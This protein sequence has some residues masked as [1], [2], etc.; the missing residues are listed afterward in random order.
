VV[1]VA[2]GFEAGIESAAELAEV[3]ALRADEVT[4][5]EVDQDALL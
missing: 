3:I 4:G 1:V 5:I 2:V